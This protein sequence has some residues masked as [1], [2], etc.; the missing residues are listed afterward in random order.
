MAELSEQEQI[1][2]NSLNEL[3]NLGIT[4]MQGNGFYRPMPPEELLATLEKNA[5]VI[6]GEETRFERSF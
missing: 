5:A 3:K 4:H 2:R 1:R 6:I